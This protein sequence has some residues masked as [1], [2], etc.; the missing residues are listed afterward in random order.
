LAVSDQRKNLLLLLPVLRKKPVLAGHLTNSAKASLICR[1][2]K[3]CGGECF[4]Q[5]LPML[6]DANGK[7]RLAARTTPITI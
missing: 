3:E 1:S 5:Q 6:Y 7:G 2:G 4:P